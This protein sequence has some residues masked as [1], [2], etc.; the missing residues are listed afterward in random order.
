M[1][2]SKKRKAHHEFHPPA[3]SVRSKKNRSAVPVGIV[4][5]AII[6]MGIAYFAMGSTD[7]WLLWLLIGA[8][9]GS[10]GVIFRTADR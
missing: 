4:F 2:K 10:I 7:L 9:V 1:P 6:G 8:V 3:N 5:L